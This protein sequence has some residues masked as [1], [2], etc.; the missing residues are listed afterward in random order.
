MA[1]AMTPLTA[2]TLPPESRLRLA[3]LAP[4]RALAGLNAF[5]RVFY[6]GIVLLGLGLALIW[7]P[8]GLIVPGAALTLVAFILQLVRKA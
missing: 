4:L 6:G 5:E 2:S 1:L 3:L 8:L 7:P